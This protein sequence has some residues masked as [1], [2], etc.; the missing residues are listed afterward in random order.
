MGVERLPITPPITKNQ[1]KAIL[2][3]D[4]HTSQMRHYSEEKGWHTGGYCEEGCDNLHVH[5]ISPRRIESDKG[6]TREQVNDPRNLITLYQC[7]H[8]G[9]CRDRKMEDREKYVPEWIR[10]DNFEPMVE[11]PDVT[12]ATRTYDGS[13]RSFQHMIELR[14]E[15]IALGKKYW[16]DEHDVELRETAEERTACTACAGWHFPEVGERV[17]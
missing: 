4:N 16:Q 17:K 13:P 3:R 15:A 8:V 9:I 10:D 7:E 5:H 6:K 1:R 12:Y 11:H 2:E 14:N